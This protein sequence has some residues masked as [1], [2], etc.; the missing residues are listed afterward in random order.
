MT[1][2]LTQTL[3][4]SL[5]E[6]R[7]CDILTAKT[8][9]TGP[10]KAQITCDWRFSQQYRC[11]LYWSKVAAKVTA[12][13]TTGSPKKD[14]A[15]TDTMHE[16]KVNQ[17][18]QNMN[19][20]YLHTHTHSSHPSPAHSTASS[21]SPR[22][23]SQRPLYSRAASPPPA[24]SRKMTGKT[25]AGAP[26]P[27]NRLPAPQQHTPTLFKCWQK[28]HPYLPSVVHQR[29]LLECNKNTVYY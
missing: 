20:N 3:T 14:N 7:T 21:A 6:L 2:I 11:A 17:V 29:C 15:N 16:R 24:S 25:D 5:E 23:C 10:A 13:I 18:K 9:S 8:K 12:T 26:S 1:I 22:W 27:A 28:I 19:H 4:H